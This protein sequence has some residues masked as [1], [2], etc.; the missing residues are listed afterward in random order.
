LLLS[1]PTARL[2]PVLAIA[3][4]TPLVLACWLPTLVVPPPPSTACCV[5]LSA[6]WP[7]AVASPDPMSP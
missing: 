2:P 4:P 1:L 3:M 5:V 6:L 7:T